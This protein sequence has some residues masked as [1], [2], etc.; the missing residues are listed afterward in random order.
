MS[1]VDVW[2]FNLVSVVI[3]TFDNT[4]YTAGV[5]KWCYNA[6]YLYLAYAVRNENAAIFHTPNIRL[7]EPCAVSN[8]IKKRQSAEWNT[9]RRQS[10]MCIWKTETENY[11]LRLCFF[12][13]AQT[14]YT[15]ALLLF[16]SK[17]M[18]HQWILAFDYTFSCYS[19]VATCL[20]RIT[21]N[22]KIR[23]S[24]AVSKK[25]LLLWATN[26]QPNTNLFC[27]PVNF[28]NQVLA[29]FSRWNDFQW[30]FLINFDKLHTKHFLSRFQQFIIKLQNLTSH[31][32]KI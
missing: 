16:I 22:K 11:T 3:N 9:K 20:S 26:T 17:Q 28:L 24:S 2:R 32:P 23:E 18:R 8:T 15:N 25:K 7:S 13:F 30:F 12:C 1:V 14:V 31:F 19:C 10:F 29:I 5:M 6:C 21:A 27:R 4:Q